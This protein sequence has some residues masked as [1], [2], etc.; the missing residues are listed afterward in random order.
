MICLPES[1]PSFSARDTLN[2]V[3]DT[4]N[5]DEIRA[6]TEIAVRLQRGAKTY[7]HLDLTADARDFE[8]EADEELDDALFYLAAAR[9]KRRARAKEAR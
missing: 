7:G 6:M 9:L 5:A 4:L 2:A 3:L 8:Q 1:W